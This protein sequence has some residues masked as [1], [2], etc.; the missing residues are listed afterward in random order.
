MTA[1][2]IYYVYAYLRKDGTPYYIGKGSGNRITAPHGKVPIPPEHRRV[3]LET[4][5]SE[6]GAFAIERRL[7]RWLGKKK[8]GG[9]LL[10]NTDGG[11]G[12]S[13][14]GWSHDSDFSENLSNY[15]KDTVAAK[16]IITGERK[17]ISKK[18]FD[19]CEE[20]VGTSAGIP[21]R[22]KKGVSV[23]KGKVTC[24]DLR[25]LK[26][27]SVTKE[28]YKEKDYYVHFTSNKNPLKKI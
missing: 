6:I 11:D 26:G 14:G 21:N 25:T 7:I 28:E 8:N 1:Q 12:S 22:K 15:L 18:L 13:G 17:R 27:V 3:Y 19:S 20:W 10:N 23:N 5:L 16:N 24:L 4:N 2:L 9:I